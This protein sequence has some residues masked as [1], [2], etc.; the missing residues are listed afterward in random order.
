MH[1]HLAR[2]CRIREEVDWAG[3]TRPVAGP[4]D[5]GRDG[6][7]EFIMTTVADRHPERATRLLT[8]L[9]RVRTAVYTGST[10]SFDLLAAWQAEVL[11][12][13]GVGFRAGPAY[14]KGGRERYGLYSDTVTRFDRCL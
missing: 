5:T 12:V 14:A 9:Q 13:P 1:D 8:A 3:A 11:G 6:V 4:I 7:A 2:W 10:L